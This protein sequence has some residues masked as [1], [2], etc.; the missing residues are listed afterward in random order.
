MARRREWAT[1]LLCEDASANRIA[2]RL[3][4][5]YCYSGSRT[6]A[7]PASHKLDDA[8]L[9]RVLDYISTYHPTRTA[10]VSQSLRLRS[11]S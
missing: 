7:A 4:H 5:G 8:R 1:A 10:W 11:V 6:P 2:A 3:L 9:R